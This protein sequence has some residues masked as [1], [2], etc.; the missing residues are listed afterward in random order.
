MFRFGFLAVF[1]LLVFLSGAPCAPI[2]ALPEPRS[3]SVA[4]AAGQTAVANSIIITNESGAPISNYPFQFGRPFLVGAVP[5]EPQVLI[6]GSPVPTQADVK[7]C[8][9][10]GSVEFAVIAVVIPTIPASGSLTLTFQDQLSANNTPQT[11]AQMLNPLNYNLIALI[12]FES[13]GGITNTASARLMLQNGDYKLWTSGPIAQTIILADDTATRK[14]DIG[15]G[16]GYHPLRPRFYLTFWPATHQV[17]VRVIVE[18]GLTTELED[19]AYTATVQV[20][21]VS[22]GAGGSPAPTYTVDLS[23][24]Q[25]THPKEHWART[26]WTKTF[27]IGGTP[28]PQVNIDNNLAY[29]EST[30]FL[31]NFDTSIQVP[32]ATVTSY[33]NN[34]WLNIP[35]DIYDGQWDGGAWSNVMGV[36]GASTHIGPYPQWTS[37]W[38]HSNGNWQMRQLALGMADLAGAFPADFR[39]SDPTR[40]LLRSDPAGLNPSTGLGHVMSITD[41]TTVY[42]PDL[43]YSGTT[44]HDKVTIVGPIN[45]NQPWS[46]DGAHQP[47]AF[48]PQYILTGDP[49]YL[50]MM[51]AWAGFSNFL[52][53]G[54]DT[55]A[56]VSGQ[57]GRGPTGQEGGINDQL[58]GA[59]WVARNRAETAFAAPDS[60][61]EKTYFTYLMN[62][63]IARWEG[64]F[65]ITGTVYD[66]SAE[67]V[68]GAAVGDQYAINGGSPPDPMSGKPPGLG[69]WL[70]N[71]NAV[72]VPTCL[73]VTVLQQPGATPEFTSIVGS[74]TT[75]WMQWY[76]T[77]S[78]GRV[79]E[80]GFAIKAL[81]AYT[82]TYLLGMINNSGDPKLTALYEAPAESTSGVY[83]TT[84]PEME[85]G[86]TSAYLSGNESDGGLPAF[87][88]SE[89]YNEGYQAYATP[90]LA[91]LVDAGDTGAAQAWQWWQAN[92]YSVLN[93]SAAVAGSSFSRDPTW[94]IVP[95]TDNNMLPPQPTATP[96]AN[97]SG[98]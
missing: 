10:G 74:F 18:N 85:S 32:V 60:A 7:N 50:D 67:K 4:N 91:M 92:V 58:R 80:L 57:G 69:N 63:A 19:M 36:A 34:N 68:W 79:A 54:A 12:S 71:C 76:N 72:F 27:W 9:A 97:L 1:S 41:R 6:N 2:T 88:A 5:D 39:E 52:Y 16:D 95:R 48:Y 25:P 96:P 64:G 8:Y 70:S 90:G 81:S 17:W 37:M 77:Y 13:T 61:P 21:A 66:G 29:L 56:N 47:A 30:R 55:A 62:D 31:P 38:L 65:Q 33:A 51:Y 86:L 22:P 11:Q 44:A 98:L 42:A 26:R 59:G 82:G 20:G 78:F 35:H 75:P 15:F 83:F 87:F 3:W 40:R 14:Y 23:G 89:L 46:I 45:L 43:T 84:W 53:N 49:W 94:A 73:D 28:S 93:S 24:D